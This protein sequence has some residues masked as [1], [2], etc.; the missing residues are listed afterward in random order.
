MNI[1][2]EN[3]TNDQVYVTY[4]QVFRHGDRNVIGSYPNSPFKNDSF[5]PGGRGALSK[6][7]KQE[8]YK[9]G[10][11]LRARYQSLI[12]SGYS[13]NQ[14]YIRSTDEDRNL[15]S[16]ECT[17]AG[18]FTP[19]GE[20]I[21]NEDLSWQP[22]PIHSVPG[23]DDYV[24][25]SFVRCDRFDELFHKRLNSWPLKFLMWRHFFLIKYLERKSGKTLRKVTDVWQIYSDLMIEHRNNL[26]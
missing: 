2:F 26:T 23:D 8:Q 11:Y 10:K 16:T 4:S 3:I 5:W 15:M 21:W 12:G 9:L 18:L 7:G 20:E 17:M 25:N 14:V 19:S 13:P 24:L 1:I 22:I 6:V